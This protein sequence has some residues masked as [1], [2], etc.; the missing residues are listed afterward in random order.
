LL[1]EAAGKRL[2][3]TLVEIFV[4]EPEQTWIGI[5]EHLT[6]SLTFEDALQACPGIQPK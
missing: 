2:D 3:P 1:R 4:A 5:E 6:D